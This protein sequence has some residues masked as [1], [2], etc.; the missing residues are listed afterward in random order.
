MEF[1]KLK[2]KLRWSTFSLK[3]RILYK[4]AV[5]NQLPA[6]AIFTVFHI[7]L[8][9]FQ[10]VRQWPRQPLLLSLASTV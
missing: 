5:G 3:H 2:F 4:T 8:L 1:V 9:S 10:Q 6:A 7:F